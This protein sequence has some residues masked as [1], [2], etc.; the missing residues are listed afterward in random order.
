MKVFKQHSNYFG[1]LVF[2]LQK[3]TAG[4]VCVFCYHLQT[5]IIFL[6]DKEAINSSELSALFAALQQA[7]Y[8]NNVSIY[9]DGCKDF[10]VMVSVG[11]REN[12]K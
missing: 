12:I 6:P 8:H 2:H 4:T 11:N 7:T 3:P 5:I 9:Y 10:T 1:H